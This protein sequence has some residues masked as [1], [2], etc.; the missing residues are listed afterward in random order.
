MFWVPWRVIHSFDGMAQI[1]VPP[2][3]ELP[4]VLM[5]WSEMTTFSVAWMLWGIPTMEGYVLMEWVCPL[6]ESYP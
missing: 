1:G 6:M 2:Y 5:E 3:G 4:L